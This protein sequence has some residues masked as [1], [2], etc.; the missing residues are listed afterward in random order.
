MIDVEESF[1]DDDPGQGHPDVRTR[2]RDVSYF[3]LGNGLISAAVQWAPSGEGTP[4]GLLVMNPEH[5]CKKREALTLDPETGLENTIL[6]LVKG[7]TGILPKKPEVGWFKELRIPAVRAQWGTEGL[8]VNEFFYCPCRV[9]AILIREIRVKNLSEK[10]DRL[11][12][13]TA[14]PGSSAT[15]EI[16][17]SAL[18]EKSF[19]LKYTLN[20][21]ENTVHMDWSSEVPIDYEMEQYW[22]KTTQLTY[23]SPLVDRFFNASCFQLPA[24]VSMSGKADA[25]IWQYNRE[26]VRD[27]AMIALGLTL[28]GHHD[29]AKKLLQRLLQEFVTKDGNTVASSRIGEPKEAELDQNGALL[30]T[31]ENYLLWTDDQH[32]ISENWDKIKALADFPFKE[33]FR[34]KPSGMPCSSREYWARHKAHG[35]KPGIEL[36]HQVFIAAGLQSAASMARQVGDHREAIRWKNRSKEIK[37]NVML[38]PDYCLVDDRGF[39]KRRRLNGKIQETVKPRRK[40]KFPPGAPL[41]AKGKHFLDPDSATALPIALGFVPPDSPVAEATMNH[42]ELLWNQEWSGGGYG[43][44][45]IS[46]EPDSPGA[47]SFPSLF[48]ARAYMETGNLAKVWRVLKWLDSIPGAKAASWF[49]SYAARLSPPFPQVGITPCTWAEMILLLVHH[50]LGVRPEPEHIRFRPKLLP[51]IG[52]IRGSLPLRDFRLH[53]NIKRVAGKTEPTFKSDTIFIRSSAEEILIPYSQEDII[54]RAEIPA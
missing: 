32:L 6:S 48:I 7:E 19:F 53:L 37:R 5:L 45:H 31:L 29:R 8:Q 9:D 11:K 47:W 14:V 22:Q 27:H 44:Y 24:V 28:S 20:P 33:S 12:L 23:D 46:S 52:K 38:H 18:E 42:I 49:E 15:D 13:K 43:R 35:I 39:I 25:S 2:L 26:G 3:F 41:S 30:Y 34:H 10:Q 4:L 21:Q 50:M 17:L 1:Y 16:T 36:I 40:A 51:E 54:I